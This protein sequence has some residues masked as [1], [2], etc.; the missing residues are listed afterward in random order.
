[1]GTYLI[2]IKGQTAA[3]GSCPYE[4]AQQTV[5]TGESNTNI[6]DGTDLGI[7]WVNCVMLQA[8][9]GATGVTGINCR[10]SPVVDA[11]NVVFGFL[12]S[13]IRSSL[14]CGA[15]NLI[16][17][18][19]INN[20]MTV[21]MFA[22]GLST[23]NAAGPISAANP[24]NIPYFALAYE[25]ARIYINAGGGSLGSISPGASL[26]YR[27]GAIITNGQPLLSSCGQIDPTQPGYCW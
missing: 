8:A 20:N 1:V 10:Q 11:I 23:I 22:S 15:I 4:R 6:I 18:M 27:G 24:V 5:L 21:F 2:K 7:P 25:G 19:W 13:G 26:V 14:G 16:G 3:D 9:P 17:N 12:S